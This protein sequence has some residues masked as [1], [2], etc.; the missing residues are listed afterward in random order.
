[1][2]K[3]RRPR[4]PN[5]LAK[6]VVDMATGDVPR[7]LESGPESPAA[8]ARRKGGIKGGMARGKK[9]SARRRKAI[10]RK[11]ALARWMRHT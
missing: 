11:A 4:D 8:A 2:K 9:L 1:M 5:Q 10:A 3:P 7:D 6:L